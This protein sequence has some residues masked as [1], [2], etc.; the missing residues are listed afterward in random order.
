MHHV[1]ADDVAQI[2]QKA[3]KNPQRAIGES[4]HVV[5]LGA[6]TLRAYAE[7][8]YKWFGHEPRLRFMSLEELEKA[9]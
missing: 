3:I 1:H 6:V 8:A 7:A 9:S 5:S 4:F 2:F